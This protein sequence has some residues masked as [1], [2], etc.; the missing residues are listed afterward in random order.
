MELASRYRDTRMYIGYTNNSHIKLPN[1]TWQKCHHFHHLTN[2]R[3]C[4][5]WSWYIYRTIHVNNSTVAV[6]RSMIQY[7]IQW[8]ISWETLK[9]MKY[10]EITI[11]AL[12]LFSSAFQANK[13]FEIYI[14]FWR[15][16]QRI[17]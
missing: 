3:S 13:G 17:I 2:L 5:T 14:N 16:F 8:L 1:Q 11:K 15:K 12:S 7:H 6:Q 10:T 9:T 4:G